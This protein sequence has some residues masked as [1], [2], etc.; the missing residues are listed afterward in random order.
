MFGEKLMP[1]YTESFTLLEEAAEEEIM[2]TKNKS[3]N[4]KWSSKVKKQ[5]NKSDMPEKSATS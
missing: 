5:K 2:A 4:F 1:S 3:F